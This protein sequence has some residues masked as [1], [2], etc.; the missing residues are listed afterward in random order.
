MFHL[1]E[2]KIEIEKRIYETESN[3]KKRGYDTSNLLKYIDNS[4]DVARN[5]SKYWHFGDLDT[6]RRIQKLVFPQGL[7][8]DIPKRVYL[9]SK[10][11]SVFSLI[12]GLSWI[13]EDEKKDDSGFIP[14]SSYAV[15]GIGLEPMTFGL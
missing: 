14:E 3:L 4:I 11:N 7:T 10:V 8:V 5:I 13:A 1:L 2:F 12:N 9:T 15:A 6:K